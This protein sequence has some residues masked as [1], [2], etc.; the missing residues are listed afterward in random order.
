LPLPLKAQVYQGDPAIGAGLAVAFGAETEVI[1]SYLFPN[2]ADPAK[3]TEAVGIV[4]TEIEGAAG[5][6][7]IDAGVFQRVGDGYGLLSRI[8]IYGTEP[9]EVQFLPDRWV[10]T[11][12]MPKPD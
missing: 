4:Y 9:R 1:D 7:N 12:T 8:E 3:A 5:N 6:F 10:V 11:T 2:D